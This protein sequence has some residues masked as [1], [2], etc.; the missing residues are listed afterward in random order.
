MVTT[1]YT[2][3]L[4]A[5]SLACPSRK[6]QGQRW[7]TDLPPDLQDLVVPPVSMDV[8]REYEM[9]AERAQGRDA[10]NAPCF[11]EF[12]YVL[13]QLRSDDDE[14]FYEMP[15][16]AET[17]TTWRLIDERWLV[18][19][20]TLDRLDYSGSNTSFAISNTMPR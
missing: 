13:T 15:V 20:T 2:P 19:R 1:L 16:F 9:Q 14:V 10:A 8:F 6:V 4:N 18:C 7:L 17:L 11:S 12:R 3:L 5:E